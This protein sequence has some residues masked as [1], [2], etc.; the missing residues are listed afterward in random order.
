MLVSW[1]N[2]PTETET[3]RVIKM[4]CKEEFL[5]EIYGHELLCAEI[6][7][8]S[9][10]VKKTAL[11]PVGFTVVD[12]VCFLKELDFEYDNGWGSQYV[13]GII[14]YADGTWS[15]RGALNGLEWWVYKSSPKIPEE[16]MNN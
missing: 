11:L 12:A 15:E 7:Y 2:D 1:H 14:W 5:S 3:P 8:N 16:L 6:R 9:F 4:N 10:N 13:F